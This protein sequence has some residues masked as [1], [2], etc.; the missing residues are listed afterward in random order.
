M[1]WI[2]PTDIQLSPTM[3]DSLPEDLITRIKKVHATF[4]DVDESSLDKWIDDFKRD[5][6][7]E[8]NIRIWEDMV[9]AYDSFCKNQDLQLET[10][11]EVFKVVLLRSMMPDNDVLSRLELEH[12]TID[13]VKSIL[14][15][16][17]G[18]AKPIE[19]IQTSQ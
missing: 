3:H 17:P 5:L 16:Y 8:S 18:K 2:D 15:A 14:A 4:A 11:E 7:P 12:I 19:V 1:E 10:R 13:D 9:V 6:D